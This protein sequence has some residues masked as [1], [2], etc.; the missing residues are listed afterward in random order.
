LFEEDDDVNEVKGALLWP[1]AV[2]TRREV[3]GIFKPSSKPS[4]KSS[5]E[6]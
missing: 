1:K 2:E 4:Y 5:L 6:R 3:G